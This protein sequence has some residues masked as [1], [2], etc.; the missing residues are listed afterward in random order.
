MRLVVRWQDIRGLQKFQRQVR[1][2][3]DKFPKVL[4]RIVNQVGDRAKTKVVRALT[5]QTGLERGVIVRAVK[6]SQ[7]AFTGRLAYDLRSKGGNI[8]LKYFKPRETE[9][10]VSATPWGKRTVYVGSFMRGGVFPDRKVVPR[11]DVHVY[12]RLNRS[13]SRI[14]QTRSGVVIPAVMIRGMAREAFIAEAEIVLPQ[15]VDQVI[16]KL[17]A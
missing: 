17:M 10:G 6:N 9:V 7:R 13:G 15:R 16:R 4:P 3:N 2:L 5:E 11:F 8:R 14:T 12:H 1:D